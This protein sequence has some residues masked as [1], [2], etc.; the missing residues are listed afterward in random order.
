MGILE[1]G[2][3]GRTYYVTKNLLAAHLLTFDTAVN[4]LYLGGQYL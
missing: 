3:D 2:G 4:Q 1:D